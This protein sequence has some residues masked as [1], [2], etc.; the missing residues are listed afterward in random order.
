MCMVVAAL[1]AAFDACC[2]L[3]LCAV[4]SLSL[5]LASSSSCSVRRRA[6]APQHAQQLQERQL[7]SRLS[8]SVSAALLPQRAE[9]ERGI[10][11]NRGREGESRITGVR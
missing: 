6:T 10:E 8:A 5:S 7:S 2:A 9:R 3:L 1:A 11:S 4:C